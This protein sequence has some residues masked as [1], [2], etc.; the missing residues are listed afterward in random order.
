MKVSHEI[1]KPENHRHP[2]I[3]HVFSPIFLIFLMQPQ[4]I[5]LVLKPLEDGSAG[6]ELLGPVIG[7]L[8]H[9]RVTGYIWLYYVILYIYC[10]LYM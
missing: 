7:M 4:V 5:W 6:F 10:I 2:F 8:I 1:G 3:T 9:M